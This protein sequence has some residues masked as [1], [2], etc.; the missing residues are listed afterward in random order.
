MPPKPAK[1][2]VGTFNTPVLE[3]YVEAPDDPLTVSV[4]A[5]LARAFV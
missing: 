3:L 1:V 4:I 2:Y 5:A